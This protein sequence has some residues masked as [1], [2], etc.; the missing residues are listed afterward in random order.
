M[1]ES[2]VFENLTMTPDDRGFDVDMHGIQ[3]RFCIGSAFEVREI[4][5]IQLGRRQWSQWLELFRTRATLEGH[6]G[7][8]NELDFLQ[9]ILWTMNDATRDDLLVRTRLAAPLLHA[10]LEENLIFRAEQLI[11]VN[12]R[13]IQN[14][15]RTVS[16]VEIAMS[17]IPED[18]TLFTKFKQNMSRR[19]LQRILDEIRYLQFHEITEQ[20]RRVVDGRILSLARQLREQGD[21]IYPVE[22]A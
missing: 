19:R 13:G 7:A 4:P 12:D 6:E 14:I 8:P 15:L 18:E 22:A 2:I 17:S 5:T 9:F 1:S 21:L 3:F 16:D 10:F 20:D 11:D